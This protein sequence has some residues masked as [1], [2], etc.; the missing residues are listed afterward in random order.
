VTATLAPTPTAPSLSLETQSPEPCADK[1]HNAGA[2]KLA[3]ST[4]TTPPLPP[5]RSKCETGRAQT[6]F[7]RRL[8]HRYFLFHC[9]FLLINYVLDVFHSETPCTRTLLPHITPRRQKSRN[10]AQ[11]TLDVVWYPLPRPCTPH[12][13]TAPN[14]KN[15]S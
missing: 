7:N 6:T 12:H 1:R 8:Q 15:D 14:N 5:S 2:T 9:L 3:P 10:M 13:A 11:T 4:P